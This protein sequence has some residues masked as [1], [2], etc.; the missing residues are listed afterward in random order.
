MTMYFLKPFNSSQ[1]PSQ[2]TRPST[3]NL[4][5]VQKTTRLV[6]DKTSNLTDSADVEFNSMN[7]LDLPSTNALIFASDEARPF[8]PSLA[9]ETHL[10]PPA[11][12]AGSVEPF[13][14][15]SFM[16]HS[17][18]SS[19][20]SHQLPAGEESDRQLRSN[21]MMGIQTPQEGVRANIH[22]LRRNIHK[23]HCNIHVV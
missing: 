18:S 13:D 2:C 9:E 14:Y 8:F 16:Q 5:S 10:L 21:V 15:I 4:K 3:P 17:S 11:N 7:A 23:I 12:D 1:F 19:S 6:G 20:S 22:N